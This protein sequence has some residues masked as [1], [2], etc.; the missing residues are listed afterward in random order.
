[1]IV[2][3]VVRA[4]WVSKIHPA[5]EGLREWYDFT[6][7]RRATIVSIPD[8]WQQ[9]VSARITVRDAKGVTHESHWASVYKDWE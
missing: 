7:Y 5:T 9:D 3:E 1:M 6:G 8:G 4:S 2:G